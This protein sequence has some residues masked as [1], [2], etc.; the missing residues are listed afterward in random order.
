[1]TKTSALQALCRL[2]DN[3]GLQHMEEK[4]AGGSLYCFSQ[5]H[6]SI[7]SNGNKKLK[8]KTN[9]TAL[10]THSIGKAPKVVW[11]NDPWKQTPPPLL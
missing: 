6:W 4:D 2:P 8:K 7:Q 3:L 9:Q 1:M 10:G 5:K 11:I